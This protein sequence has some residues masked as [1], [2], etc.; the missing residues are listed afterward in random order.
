[1]K[2]FCAMTLAFGLVASVLTAPAAAF[3]QFAKEFKNVYVGDE[4]TPVQQ[5]LAAAVAE[6][7]CDVCHDPKKGPDGK[8]SKKNRNAYGMALGKLLTKDDKKDVEKI[9]SALKTV[10]S[11]KAEG[12]EHTFGQRLEEGKL[13]VDPPADE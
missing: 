6:T 1:M 3:P 11:Q 4:T 7:K 10:E 8:A 13:P 2:R 12:A 9:H 5:K